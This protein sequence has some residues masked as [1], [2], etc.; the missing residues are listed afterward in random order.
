MTMMVMMMHSDAGDNV[1]R[2]RRDK[3]CCVIF[4]LCHRLNCNCTWPR[5]GQSKIVTVK[6]YDAWLNEDNHALTASGKIER[7]LASVIME[8][9]SEAWKEV[10]DNMIRKSFLK[11][12]LSNAA[13]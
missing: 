5:I 12:C 1:K 10:R 11:G 13:D 6:Y 2:H 8:C 7:A 4:H 3:A 9:I